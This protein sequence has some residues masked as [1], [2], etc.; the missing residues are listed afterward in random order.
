MD[1]PLRRREALSDKPLRVEFLMDK[2]LQFIEALTAKPR[3][4]GCLIDKPLSI[5]EDSYE[6]AYR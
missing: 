1:K 2:P 5:D 3:R 6:C 4:E